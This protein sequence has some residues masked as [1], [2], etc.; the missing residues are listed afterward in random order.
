MKGLLIRYFVIVG[1]LGVSIWI[2]NVLGYRIIITP[3][4]PMGIWR[5]SPAKFPLKR[6][7]VVWL[8]P[9]DTSFFRML[10]E[11]GYYF[12]GGC[13]GNYIHMMKPVAAIAGDTVTLD[14]QSVLVN[15]KRL[16]NSQ[17]LKQDPEGRAFY[18]IHPGV[19]RVQPGTVWLLSTYNS[20]SIDSR[21]FGPISE[22]F[23][24]TTAKPVWIYLIRF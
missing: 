16:K 8:C 6:G 14:E 21:Y 7:Q 5:L 17:I 23:I 1:L 13:P 24:E 15:G 20:Q 4:I 22:K 19:Y 2:F 18:G 9:P 10:K 11:R 3:S 12:S